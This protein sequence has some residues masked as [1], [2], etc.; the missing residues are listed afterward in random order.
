MTVVKMNRVNSISK[1]IGFAAGEIDIFPYARARS[2]GRRRP[3][4]GAA[5][6]AA[7][8]AAPPP[9]ARRRRR[10]SSPLL[11]CASAAL[12][13]R[14]S[15]AARWRWEGGVRAA[16]HAVAR[17]AS[18]PRGRCGCAPMPPAAGAAA[19]AAARRCCEGAARPARREAAGGREGSREGG[20][21]VA[22]PIAR[23][24]GMRAWRGRR[25]RRR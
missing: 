13:A 8:A 15:R 23:S 4:G 19:A 20:R 18:M 14:L 2:A 12:G 10:R 22:T 1:C 3:V 7:A 17:A 16:S 6:D 21:G 5:A 24:G 9:H 11:P 25:P